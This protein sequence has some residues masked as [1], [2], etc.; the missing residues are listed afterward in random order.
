MQKSA[1][2][3]IKGMG[4]GMIAGASV[5]IIGKAVLTDKHSLSK[6]SAKVI[7]AAGEFVD[8]I[9]TMFK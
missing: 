3:F 4:A 8:G 5:T 9:Q 7:K 2:S 6:G 1:M